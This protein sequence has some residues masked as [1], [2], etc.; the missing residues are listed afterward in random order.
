MPAASAPDVPLGVVTEA[1]RLAIPVTE[2]PANK[3]LL[4]SAVLMALTMASRASEVLSAEL[5]ASRD[6][7]AEVKMD[8]IKLT[9]VLES[10]FEHPCRSGS[11]FTKHVVQSTWQTVPE[12]AAATMA[13]KAST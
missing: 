9:S 11:E 5:I 4:A 1:E 7:T 10:F 3:G 6:T 2:I 13:L 12:D 8:K